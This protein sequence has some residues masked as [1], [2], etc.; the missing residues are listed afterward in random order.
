QRVKKSAGSS[1]LRT[2]MPLGPK[3]SR[4][5]SS[6][7]NSITTPR[8]KSMESTRGRTADSTAAAFTPLT[9]ADTSAVLNLMV[10][11]SYSRAMDIANFQNR[12]FDWGVG[13]GKEADE[14]KTNRDREH[15]REALIKAACRNE[16]RTRRFDENSSPTLFTP[17]SACRNRR[18]LWGNL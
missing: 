13:A 15:Y 9:I 11:A 3:K 6:A 7:I 1:T 5:W 14:A 16:A 12:P 18:I 17:R 10:M 8:N 4:V 2:F